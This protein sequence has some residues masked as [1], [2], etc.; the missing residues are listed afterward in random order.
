PNDLV[1]TSIDAVRLGLDVVE[2]DLEVFLATAERAMDASRRGHYRA[3]EMARTALDLHRG[4]ALPDEPHADW[5]A[6]VRNE[7]RAAFVSWAR[8]VASE[9]LRRGDRLRAADVFRRLRDE[10]LYDEEAH[11]G[12][13]RAFRAMGAHG[14][15][16]AAYDTY[17]ARMVDLGV[18]AAPDPTR[19]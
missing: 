1:T 6:P 9:G 4:E 2:V 8:L 3:L 14:Q 16:D 13:T 12:R 17:R 19:R 7:V 5:A 10:D 11:L 15:A 18:P